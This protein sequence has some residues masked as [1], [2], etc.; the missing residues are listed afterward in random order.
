LTSAK[1]ENPFKDIRNVDNIVAKRGA[2]FMIDLKHELQQM[3]VQVIHIKTD[4]IKLPNMVPDAGHPTKILDFVIEFGKKYGYEFELEAIYDKFC[5][6]NDAVYIAGLS[7]VPWD[8]MSKPFPGYEWKT[9]GSQFQHPYVYKMLFSHEELTFD[10]FCET[11]NVTQGTMYL[12]KENHEDLDYRNM[13]HL[14]RTGRFVPVVAEGGTLYRVK[15]DRYYAVSG[16]KDHLWIEAEIAKD[17]PNLEIDMT[18]FD[19]LKDDAI[20]TIN[21]FGSYEELV[22]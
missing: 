15:D 18:Y 2:L 7:T 17:R 12:D 1:F 9:V 19:K 5:L 3:G 20:Q 4:S 10:D 16:T 13:R 6:V 22:R 21:K 8:D 14:G 11:K